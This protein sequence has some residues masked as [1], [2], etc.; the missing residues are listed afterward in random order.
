MNTRVYVNLLEGNG[1]IM[2]TFWHIYRGLVV[3]SPAEMHADWDPRIQVG[4]LWR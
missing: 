4:I 2:G 1:Y 3:I